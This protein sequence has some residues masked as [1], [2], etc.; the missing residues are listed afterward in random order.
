MGSQLVAVVSGASQ[1]IG[2]ATALRLA[3]DFAA[4]EQVIEKFPG[5]ALL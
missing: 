4:V 2:K 5:N 1:A 3:R